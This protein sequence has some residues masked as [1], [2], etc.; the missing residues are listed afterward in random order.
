VRYLLIPDD[1]S[2]ISKRITPSEIT[3]S[4]PGKHHYAFVDMENEEEANKAIE[5]LD[6]TLW[7]GSPLKVRVPIDLPEKI[8]QRGTRWRSIPTGSQ[9]AS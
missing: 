2:A 8:A 4:K 5:A 6:G 7:N 9:E 3:R 1:R